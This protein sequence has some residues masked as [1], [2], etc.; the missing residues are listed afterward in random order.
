M[1]Y[2]QG[3]T[4]CNSLADEGCTGMAGNNKT[5]TNKLPNEPLV[6]LAQLV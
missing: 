6:E 4:L 5:N 2:R 3:T 1:R